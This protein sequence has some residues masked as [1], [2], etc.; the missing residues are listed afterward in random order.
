MMCSVPWVERQTSGRL[1][2]QSFQI[3]QNHDHGR[4]RF[5]PGLLFHTMLMQT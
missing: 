5:I 4:A 1:E 3:E 2:G